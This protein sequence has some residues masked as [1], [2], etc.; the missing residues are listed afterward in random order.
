MRSSSSSCVR[1]GFD[2][3]DASEAEPMLEADARLFG[4]RLGFRFDEGRRR[5]GGDREPGRRCLDALRDDLIAGCPGS[6][7]CCRGRRRCWR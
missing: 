2:D 1:L 3:E 4:F 5:D 7:S 6:P